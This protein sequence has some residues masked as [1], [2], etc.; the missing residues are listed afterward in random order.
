MS[1]LSDC[2]TMLTEYQS[3]NHKLAKM[4]S[5]M[6]VSQYNRINKMNL[7]LLSEIQK[8]QQKYS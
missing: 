1:V 3:Y 4:H 7:D 2:A 6:N 5:K 8:M